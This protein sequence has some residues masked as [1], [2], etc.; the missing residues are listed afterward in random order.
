MSK[1]STFFV[2]VLCVLF[3]GCGDS[4]YKG[5]QRFPLEGAATYEG[6]PI[7]LGAIS[8]TPTGETSGRASGGVITDGKYLI[9]EEKGPNAGTYR[10]E[11]HWLKLTGK[12]LLDQETGEMY[13]QRIE[14]LPD[15][16]HKKS[17]LSIEVPAP[18][19][20]HDFELKSS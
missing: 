13:D 1:I 8:L 3:A 20:T 9:P 18:E 11:I 12:Q 6:Q 7:D 14:A 2:L 5:D 16:F 17:E 4:K 15:K 19:N 10:V